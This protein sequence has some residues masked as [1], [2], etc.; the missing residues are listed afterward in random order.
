VTPR[1]NLR[2][3][4]VSVL[5][6]LRTAIADGS[7]R[8]PLDRASL[9]GFGVRSQLDAI[10]GALAGHMSAACLAVLDVALAERSAPRPVPELVWTGPEAQS[11]TARD[12]AVVLR[13]LFEQARE[14]V[15]L[16]GY[17][18]S[19][20]H[21]VLAPLYQVMCNHG[22][23]ARFF[24]H[25][26]QIERGQDARAHLHEQLDAFLVQSWPFGEP[27]PRVYYDKRALVPGPPYSSLHAKCVVIDGAKAF[28][29]S[30]NFTQR[31]HERNIE[32]GVLIDDSSFAGS[33]AAQWLGLI[34]AQVV[35]EYTPSPITR[36]QSP[37]APSEPPPPVS[38]DD[39]E[40]LALI[41]QELPEAL[42]L[43][44]QLQEGACPIPELDFCLR[45]ARGAIAAEALLHWSD[46][47]VVVA[48]APTPR[49]QEAWRVAGYRVWEADE[50]F[51]EPE[52][53]LRCLSS[54][55]MPEG[56]L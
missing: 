38:L 5:S 32:V 44:A 33:L 40:A 55:R 18:F 3:V 21:D 24:V 39:R 13:A 46:A 19:H 35:A 27:R 41:A 9:V 30:A 15:I 25:I 31:A 16:G 54:E 56:R 12:T 4:S 11:G 34:D 17:S 48:H 51:A 47:K 20:A 22:V 50:V 37:V 2:G 1:A 26:P 43:C 49:E 52:P 36:F 29:S 28:V 10:A 6:Q 23:A 14:T 45:D 8:A 7:L 42:Q 53:L